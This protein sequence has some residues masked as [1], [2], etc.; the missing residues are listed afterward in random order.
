MLKFHSFYTVALCGGLSCLLV[1]SCF[2]PGPELAGRSFKPNE[3]EVSAQK[4]GVL[5]LNMYLRKVAGVRVS[6]EG[7]A[8]RITIRGLNSINLDS[9]PL[10][11][12]DGMNLGRDYSQIYA[13][14]NVLDIKRV[15]VLKSAS[16]LGI[17]GVQGANGV[18]EIEMKQ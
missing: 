12:V 6:G 9:S 16:E 5:D 8:A 17:Y 14:L 1:S 4:G 2:T 15:S 3:V 10:F 11:I 13:M 7:G 18:I